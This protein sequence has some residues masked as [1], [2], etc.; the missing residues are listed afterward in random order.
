MKRL[1][2]LPDDVTLALA[3]ADR[4]P[5]WN[6]RPR[7]IRRFLLSKRYGDPCALYVVPFACWAY[8][9]RDHKANTG[10]CAD[11]IRAGK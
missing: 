4:S 8:R 10:Q 9:R 6:S 3:R 2:P 7:I 1:P 5:G 11:L